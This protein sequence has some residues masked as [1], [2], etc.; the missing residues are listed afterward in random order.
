MQKNAVLIVKLL[1]SSKKGKTLLKWSP[2]C[3]VRVMSLYLYCAALHLY[4]SLFVCYENSNVWLPI[5][6]PGMGTI[7]QLPTPK[8]SKNNFSC[9]VQQLQIILPTPENRK[10]HLSTDL[11]TNSTLKNWWKS[12]ASEGFWKKIT[13]APIPTSMVEMTVF[14]KNLQSLLFVKF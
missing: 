3:P 12:W 7:G 4:W 8:I 2:L 10:Y 6:Q 11:V 5:P 13:P 9:W 1:L 14:A